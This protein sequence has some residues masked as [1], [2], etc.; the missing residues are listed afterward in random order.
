MDP[1]SLIEST[2]WLGVPV[3][4]VMGA[5]L[6]ANPAA[7]PMLGTAI[8]F[9]SAGALAAR[10]GAIKV[11]AGFGAG[12]VVVYT[13]VG[14][15]A[16]RVDDLT[17]SILRPYSGI[18]YLILGILISAFALFL[19]FRPSAFCSACAMPA[20]RNATVLGAFIAGIPA[21]LVNCPACAGVVIGVAA[22]AAAFG[23]AVY[24]SVVM[25]ALG[26]GHAG[27]LV[28][29]VWFFTKGWN[30][31]PRALRI[32]QK[33]AAFFL[34]AIAAYFF[35]LSSIQGLRPGFRLV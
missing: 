12:M 27:M 11:A 35:Y 28:A 13:A 9:G 2:W 14:V 24:S 8:G 31:S 21:G 1:F 3:A 26:F 34:L 17:E 6:G 15:V 20:K 30:L 4:L 16:E 32:S 23:N 22:S 10:G 29:L 25:L 5:L 18:G 19:L 7:L 33:M